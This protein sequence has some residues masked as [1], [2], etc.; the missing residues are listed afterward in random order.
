MYIKYVHI[1][2]FSHVQCM[3]KTL[4]ISYKLFK[5]LKYVKKTNYFVLNVELKHLHI[6]K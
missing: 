1:C 6:D 5:I 3:G 4:I 2:L